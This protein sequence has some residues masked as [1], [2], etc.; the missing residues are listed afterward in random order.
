M[1]GWL[2]ALLMGGVMMFCCSKVDG[3][4][5]GQFIAVPTAL[6]VGVFGKYFFENSAPLLASVLFGFFAGIGCLY[7]G[8]VLD[9][10]CFYQSLDRLVWAIL[11]GPFALADQWLLFGLFG[12]IGAL[13]I[14]IGNTFIARFAHETSGETG[15]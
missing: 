12:I 15:I 3:A 7:V 13:A 11:I 14:R 8:S 10:F 2:Q 9:Y 1:N 4:C 5:P 6:L